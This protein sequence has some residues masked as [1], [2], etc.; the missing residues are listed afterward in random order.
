MQPEF[1]DPAYLY[2][3]VESGEKILRYA[4]NAGFSD[5][6]DNEMLRDAIERNLEILGEAARRISEECKTKHPHIP[7]RKIIALRNVLV[8]EY[9]DIN[10][11]EI[12]EIITVHLPALLPLL[13]VLIPP[14]PP[15]DADSY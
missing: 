11:E 3:M 9:D 14:L 4:G 10:P 12:W 7:W 2:D 13:K 15:V 8:H 6:L 5:F 1:R